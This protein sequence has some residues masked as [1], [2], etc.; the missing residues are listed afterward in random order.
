MCKYLCLQGIGVLVTRPAHQAEG[1]CRLIEA[2][3]GQPIRWPVITIEAPRDLSRVS[4]VIDRL[5]EFQ[6]AIFIS[7]NAVHYGI[8]LVRNRGQSLAP[9]TVVAVG[10]GTAAALK[11]LGCGAP[12]TPSSGF[13]SEG[14]LMLPLFQRE[15]IA[16]RRVLIFRGEGGR[17]LLAGVFRERGAEVEYAEVYRRAKPPVDAEIL[18]GYWDRGEVHIVLATSSEGLNNLIEMF[19]ER[20]RDKLLATPLLVISERVAELAHRVGFSHPAIVA[21]EASDQGLVEALRAWRMGKLKE[22]GSF[23]Q[24]G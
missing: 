18:K 7:T 1:L 4:Q 23:E 20:D 13:D 14:V 15:R 3:G 10:Q 5:E 9:L 19:G 2:E 21:E 6:I 22:L 12:I 8:K 17:E 16:Q 11:E 24:Q